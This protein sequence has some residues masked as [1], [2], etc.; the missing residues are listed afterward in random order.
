ME[1]RGGGGGSLRPRERDVGGR[2]GPGGWASRAGLGAGWGGGWLGWAGGGRR[3]SG[4][5]WA[6]RLPR[7]TGG[8]GSG[9]TAARVALS[10]RRARPVPARPRPLPL[11]LRGRGAAPPGAG[12]PAAELVLELELRLRLAGRRDGVGVRRGGRGGV[13]AR[14]GRGGGGGGLVLLWPCVS[15]MAGASSWP[16]G[17]GVRVWRARRRVASAAPAPPYHE[18]RERD[19]GE[20]SVLR[21]G[22]FAFTATETP[23]PVPLHLTLTVPL[24]LRATPLSF[25]AARHRQLDMVSSCGSGRPCMC[26]SDPFAVGWRGGGRVEGAS[27]PVTPCRPGGPRP[28]LGDLGGK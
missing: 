19:R 12:L 23:A 27:T 13:V 15:E 26:W 3:C 22:A 21:E 11:P 7:R 18:E 16:R 1:G 17:R 6:A 14:V 28:V 24:R 10:G 5:L 4:C 25:Y 20:R 2:A 9:V 8:A